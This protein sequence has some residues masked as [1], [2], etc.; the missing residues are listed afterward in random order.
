MTE[1]MTL[2]ADASV[3][4]LSPWKPVFIWASFVAWAWLLGTKLDDDA[5]TLQ[6]DAVKWN[7]IHLAAGTGGLCVML[8]AGALTF[9]LAFPLGLLVMVAPILVYWKVRNAEVSEERKY[10]LFAKPA[11]DAAR[12]RKRRGRRKDATLTFSGPEGEFPVPDK[13]DEKLDAYVALEGLFEP[14]L[15]EK[16]TRMD[17]AIGGGGL[18]SAIVVHSVRS[19]QEPIPGELG[20]QVVNMVKQIAGMDLSETRKRQ[21][22]TFTVSNDEGRRT[23]TATA[24]GSSKGQFIRLDVDE[25]A[26]LIIPMDALG[27]LPQQQEVLAELLDP[28]KRHGL[29]LLTSPQGQGLST[30]ALSLLAAHDAYTSNLKVLEYRTAL[31]LEGVDHIEWDA[32]NPD[33]DFATSLQSI[34]R[35]DPDVVLTEAKDTETSQIAARAGRDGSLQY[36]CFHADSTAMAIRE[37]CRLVGDVDLATKPLRAAVCQRLVRVLCPDCKQEYTPANPRKLGLPE[38]VTLYR[39]GGQVQVR[40]RVEDCPTCGGSGYSGVTALY[41]VFPV[42]EECR[43]ILA[44]GDLKAAMVHARRNKMLMLQE[45]GLQRA[46]S[47]V[48]SIE[49]VSRVLGGKSPGQAKAAPSSASAG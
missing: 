18:A 3:F 23:V 15:N 6:L 34:L 12:P 40:N 44:S 30:T 9:Y 10:R 14:L 38:G 42:D 13:E 29:V 28:Q 24:T 22:G 21:N 16:G 37:W 39:Q 5:R 19:K 35:R 47:G 36:L 17:L 1:P 4:L 26:R 2:L 11:H 45:V 32:S 27:L 7:L 43:Q 31:R 25:A 46:A 49:E 20:G 8:F 48:T 41:E 33:L